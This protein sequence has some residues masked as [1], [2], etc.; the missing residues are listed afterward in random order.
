MASAADA[1]IVAIPL[2]AVVLAVGLVTGMVVAAFY[3]VYIAPVLLAEVL[4]DG[5]LS[6]ALFRH[7]RGLDPQHWLSSAVRRTVLPFAVTAVFLVAA[8]AAMTA[9]APGAKSLG[10]VLERAAR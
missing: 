1:D 4:V 8:G 2:F 3:L 10:Q 6:Y 7:L 9:Y 5:A